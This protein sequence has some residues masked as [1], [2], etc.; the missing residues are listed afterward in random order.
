MNSNRPRDEVLSRLYRDLAREEPPAALDRRRVVGARG[1][2]DGAARR[3]RSWILRWGAPAGLAATVVLAVTVTLLV[4]RER[5]DL[6]PGRE[7]AA[8]PV[9]V[10]ASGSSM[11]PASP[12]EPPATQETGGRRE[13]AARAPEPAAA[14]PAAVPAGRPAA[15]TG[16]RREVGPG[17]TDGEASA[18]RAAGDSTAANAPPAGDRLPQLG[19]SAGG[20]E[21]KAVDRAAPQPFPAAAP[22]A[23][24]PAS[25]A[26]SAPMAAPAEARKELRGAERAAPMPAPAPAQRGLADRMAR[27]PASWLDE[28]R[29]LMREGRE[30]EARDQLAAFRRAH[31][32]HPV[33]DD[34]RALP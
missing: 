17:M 4:E 30:A 23:A 26:S 2:G 27:D 19:E 33:P 34:L 9:P 10:P 6:L 29:R 14:P 21:A 24:T 32:D 12:G 22:Q 15:A 5:H 3:R 25:P 8:T 16:G 28:I 11:S 7:P 1:V 20:R 31:P 13:S 18:R